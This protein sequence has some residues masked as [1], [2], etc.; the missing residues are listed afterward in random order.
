MLKSGKCSIRVIIDLY[1]KTFAWFKKYTCN[2]YLF[3][4]AASVFVNRVGG[5]N[6]RAN[7]RF[8]WADVG[9]SFSFSVGYFRATPAPDVNLVGNLLE[10]SESLRVR[11]LGGSDLLVQRLDSAFLCLELLL[12]EGFFFEVRPGFGHVAAETIFQLLN[13]YKNSCF[14]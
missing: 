9:F 7:A 13:L 11:K 4:T 8:S 1:K 12:A 2:F 14:N 6:L 3:T 10:L 5:T